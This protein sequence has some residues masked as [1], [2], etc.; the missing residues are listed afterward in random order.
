MYGKHGYLGSA[1]RL[2]DEMPER[3]VVSWTAVMSGCVQRGDVGESFRLMNEMRWDGVEPSSVSLVVILRAC[4]IG[5]EGD[6]VRQV[7]CFAIKRGFEHYEMVQNS[8]LMAFNKAGWFEVAEELFGSITRRSITSWNVLMSG[9]ASRG[10][11]SKVMD[12]FE[13]LRS[14]FYPTHETLTLAI[15][16]FGKLGY[17]HQGR[18]LHGLALKNGQID[19]VLEASLLDFYAKCGDLASS[20]LLFEEVREKNGSVW[21]VMMLGFIQ[22]GQFTDAIDLFRRMQDSGYEPTVDTLR[23]LVLAYTELGALRFGKSVHGC[24]VRNDLCNSFDFFDALETSILNMYAKCGCIVLAR[25]CFDRMVHKDIVA[26]SSMVEGYAIHGLGS[27]ALELF[28]HMEMEGIKPNSITFLSLLSACS[29][30]GL[31]RE[32]C[33]VLHSMSRKF[34]VQPTL[35][36]YTCMVDL[37]GRSGKLYEALEVINNMK[38]KPD[39]RIWGALLASCRI[40]RDYVLGNYVAQK[41]FNLEPDNVGYHVVFSN[42]QVGEGEWDKAEKIRMA[43]NMMNFRKKPGWSC[44]EEK[45][46]LHVFVATDTSHPLADEIYRIL[47]CLTWQTEEIGHRTQDVHS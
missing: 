36:H 46:W 10:D 37:L 23:C 8:I 22:N 34:G 32:G 26:W 47:V 20:I 41:I 17:L 43:M 21:S 1:C 33:M 24:L 16:A 42:I 45:G 15:S 7:H 19:M 40:H 30:S 4:G 11:L 18:K 28:C 6:G 35:D 2:F 39:A 38:S 44:I 27:K 25:R 29:H 3:D 31:I 9:Y 5:K 14:E 12:C 13:A